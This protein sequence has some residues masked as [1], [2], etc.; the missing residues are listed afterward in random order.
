MKCSIC[1][2]KFIKIRTRPQHDG[3]RLCQW[4]CKG[5]TIPCK[6]VTREQ[7]LCIQRP[8]VNPLTPVPIR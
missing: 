1:G 5:C 2:K 8:R 7:I 6:M 3:S 4:K